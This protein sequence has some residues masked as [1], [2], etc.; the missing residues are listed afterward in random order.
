ME[1][2]KDI[3][4]ADEARED[5]EFAAVLA[6]SS[7]AEVPAGAM[8]RLMERIAA[9]PQE[10]KVLAFPPQRPRRP[11]LFRLATALPLAASLALGVYLGARGSLDFLLPSIVTGG[12]A[13]ND[14]SPDDLGGIGEADAYAEESL[15]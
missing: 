8:S 1:Q 5:R 14:E 11:I 9:E 13:L 7:Q 15:T 6:R 2:G 10:S 3:R 12:V 4:S